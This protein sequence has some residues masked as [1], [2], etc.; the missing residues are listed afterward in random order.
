MKRFSKRV[1]KIRDFIAEAKIRTTLGM[2]WVQE[3]RNALLI[4]A[5]LKI[6]FGFSLL[7]SFIVMVDCMI[8][9]FIMGHIDL[10]HFKITPKI[11]ELNSFKYNKFK[12]SLKRKDLNSS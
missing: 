11:N 2:G 4:S 12:T 9:F 6:L 7:L 1:Y 5:S 3:T 8:A 10:N